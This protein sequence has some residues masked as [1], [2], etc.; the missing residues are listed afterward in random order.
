[1]VV[2][3]T[4]A[5]ILP[6]WLNHPLGNC[7]GTHPEQVR[8]LSYNFYSGS[9]SDVSEITLVFSALIALITVLRQVRKARA[10]Y[11]KRTECHVATCK[12]HGYVVHGTPYRACHEHHPAVE[13]EPGEDI[14][15][16]HIAA[17][18][19]KVRASIT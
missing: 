18:H 13:H 11:I 9:L 3:H 19:A 12:R 14:T 17:A 16:D 4:L 10:E 6:E 2:I 5:T 1:M 7:V 15:A 8:C